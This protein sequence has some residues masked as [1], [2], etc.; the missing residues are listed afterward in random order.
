M[1]G[2]GGGG[3]GGDGGEVENFV[4]DVFCL[5]YQLKKKVF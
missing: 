2:V 5:Y 4:F 3:G 1:G